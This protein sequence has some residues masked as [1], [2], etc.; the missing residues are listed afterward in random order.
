MLVIQS[1]CMGDV[2]EGLLRFQR[3]EYNLVFC[4]QTR[5]IFRGM[6]EQGLL[7]HALHFNMAVDMAVTLECLQPQPHLTSQGK[8]HSVPDIVKR[9]K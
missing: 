5:H 6:R 1:V 4:L 3:R 2:D 7:D 8:K 9:F